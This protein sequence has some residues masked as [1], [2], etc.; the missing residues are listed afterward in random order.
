MK[1]SKASSG[2][3][4]LCRGCG[5]P[6]EWTSAMRSLNAAT[7][8]G[9]AG[10]PNKDCEV[11]GHGHRVHDLAGD[12]DHRETPPLR[13][14]HAAQHVGR[15]LHAKCGGRFVQDQDPG[16]EVDCPQWRGTDARRPK[17]RRA[18]GHRRRSW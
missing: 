17:G 7:E 18:G 6:P 9:G 13:L 15:L 11:V 16:A 1:A 12:E 5:E 10:A 4:T 8:I 2:T 14:V 3:A